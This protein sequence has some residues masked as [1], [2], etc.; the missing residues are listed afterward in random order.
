[1]ATIAGPRSQA[2]IISFYDA[3]EKGYLFNPKLFL[4]AVVVFS[5]L[6]IVLDFFARNPKI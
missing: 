4:I 2:G 3:P 6:V 5:V 1:M